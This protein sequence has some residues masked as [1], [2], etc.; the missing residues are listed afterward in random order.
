MRSR[1]VTAGLG[2]VLMVLLVFVGTAVAVPVSGT[3]TDEQDAR[4]E[5]LTGGGVRD[6]PDLKRLSVS[7]DSPTGTITATVELVAGAGI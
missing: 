3:V 6:N 7:Y 4:P 5:V 1:V 2:V